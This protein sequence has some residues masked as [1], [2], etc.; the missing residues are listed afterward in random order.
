[1]SMIC[2]PRGTEKKNLSVEGIFERAR[3]YENDRMLKLHAAGEQACTLLE[4]NN[5]KLLGD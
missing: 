3:A 5:Y 1:M 4:V 2:K